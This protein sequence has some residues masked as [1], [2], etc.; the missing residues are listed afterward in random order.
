[1]LLRTY[2]NICLL[3]ANPQDL[4][5]SHFLLVLSLIAYLSANLVTFSDTVSW[6]RALVASVAD[7]LLLIALVHS[8]LLIRRLVVRGRQTLAAL[9]GCGAFISLIA[10]MATTIAVKAVAPDI[11]DVGT[12]A[13]PELSP[14][15][16]QIILIV[17]LLCVAWFVLVFGHIFRE[18]LNVP[19]AGGVAIAML[20]I[21]VSTS[22]GA[23]L[24][25]G[26]HSNG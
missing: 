17:S 6:A 10:W 3:R 22:I 7:T 13:L 21:L 1:M 15:Q 18:A 5:A 26:S 16:T 12:S 4:P 11:S 19:I 20:Y 14:G 8:A 9:A 25:G 24:I 23:A 2:L